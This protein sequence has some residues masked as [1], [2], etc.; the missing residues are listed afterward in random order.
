M[1]SSSAT[2]AGSTRARTSSWRS[3]RPRSGLYDYAGRQAPVEV[4]ADFV[5]IR[6]HGPGGAYQGSYSDDALAMWTRRMLSWRVHRISVYCYFDNDE[7]GYAP[8]NALTLARLVAAGSNDGSCEDPQ[9]S[10]EP[11]PA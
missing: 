1:P 4:T 5:Y 11:T 3:T 9:R 6:L 8:I 2:R 10:R 7:Q